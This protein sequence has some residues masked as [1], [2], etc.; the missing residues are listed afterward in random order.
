MAYAKECRMSRTCRWAAPRR[1]ASR[2][3]ESRRNETS[4]TKAETHKQVAQPRPSTLPLREE[5]EIALE[6]FFYV[7]VKPRDRSAAFIRS[8]DTPSFTLHPLRR[9]SG[10]EQ[11]H[12]AWVIRYPCA[13]LILTDTRTP[14]PNLVC[15]R[16]RLRDVENAR[17]YSEGLGQCQPSS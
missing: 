13:R 17:T 10:P 9:D 15:T 7:A 12:S 14:F 8:V 1:L 2:A 3:G 4:A 11:A 6:S 16:S 5:S